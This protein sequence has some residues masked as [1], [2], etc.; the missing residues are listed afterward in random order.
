MNLNNVFK[1]S[2]WSLS[3]EQLGL[4]ADV[5]L[6]FKNLQTNVCN[7]YGKLLKLKFHM[8]YRKRLLSS[9]TFLEN[10]LIN[11]KDF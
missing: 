7:A 9:E 2:M 11:M 10:I 1:K 4:W 5:Q 8:L 6:N 3:E